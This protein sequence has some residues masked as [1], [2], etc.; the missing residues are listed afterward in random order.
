[1]TALGPAPAPS[2][3]AAARRELVDAPPETREKARTKLCDLV[4]ARRPLNIVTW[5][6]VGDAPSREWILSDWLPVGTVS[7][8]YGWVGQ[9]KSRLAL[10]LAAAVAADRTGLPQERQREWLGGTSAGPQLG[11]AVP[12]EG[13]PVIFASYKDGHY[14]QSR[15]LAAVSGEAAPWVSP[16]RLDNL[17]LVDMA[18]RGPLWG[19]EKGKHTST[20]GD[21]QEAGHHLREQ[22][23]RL[24]AALVVLDPL[25]AVYRASEIDRSL[26]RDFL[27]NWEAWAREQ[28]CAVLLLAHQ[29]RNRD[30]TSGS[31]DW[32]AGARSVWT[33][34]KE[35]LCGPPETHKSEPG[36]EARRSV[37]RIGSQVAR[38]VKLLGQR[39]RLPRDRM[40]QAGGRPQTG[41]QRAIGERKETGMDPRTENVWDPPNSEAALDGLATKNLRDVH[42]DAAPVR[43]TP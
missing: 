4:A 38:Q 34:G 3:L 2:D 13:R 42:P 20:A 22:A 43:R 26:V 19:V 8:L 32:E 35:P 23:S 14:E 29:S 10:Q 18:G 5:K 17:H 39:R 1:M 27:S 33:L 21:L 6:N 11:S 24:G 31:T 37:V 36:G 25:A 16:D 28:D 30:A 15:R 41:N 12:I 7:S 40:G 9:G